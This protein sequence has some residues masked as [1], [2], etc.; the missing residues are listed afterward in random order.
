MGRQQP[1]E[2]RR[3]APDYIVLSYLLGPSRSGLRDAL[4]LA[5]ERSPGRD[6]MG[7][8]EVLVFVISLLALSGYLPLRLAAAVSALAWPS[9][10][11]R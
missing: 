7:T 6:L 2:D 8:A 9:V 10:L 3:A 4:V 5:G 11:Y 1:S